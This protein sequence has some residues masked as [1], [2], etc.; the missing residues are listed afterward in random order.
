MSKFSRSV[1]L[2]IKVGDQVCSYDAHLVMKMGMP[3]GNAQIVVLTIT[4]CWP[5]F[6]YD[7]YV[8]IYYE[9]R[10]TRF[11][12]IL[13]NLSHHNLHPV[14]VPVVLLFWDRAIHKKAVS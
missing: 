13:Y 12:R 14:A 2:I 3:S 8:F 4:N 11:L 7:Q 5:H 6:Y 1:V 9:K 10:L